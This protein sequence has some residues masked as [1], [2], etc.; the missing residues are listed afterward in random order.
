VL[1]TALAG[2]TILRI[3]PHHNA[4]VLPLGRLEAVGVLLLLCTSLLWLGDVSMT[5]SALLNVRGLLN[6]IGLLR[7]TGSLS[8]AGRAMSQTLA[9]FQLL[10][11]LLLLANPVGV[12]LIRLGGVNFDRLIAF[13]KYNPNFLVLL[14]PISYLLSELLSSLQRFLD[15]RE[16]FL[17]VFSNLSNFLL[18]W[19]NGSFAG[20]GFLPA[21]LAAQK[22]AF[23]IL[24]FLCL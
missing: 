11:I 8:V 4:V 16:A 22:L 12:A 5:S 9:I 1:V 23:T 15:L 24:S 2:V 20:L 19:A 7:I 10:T 13:S 18:N 3:T 17:Y 21:F 14:N 6:V